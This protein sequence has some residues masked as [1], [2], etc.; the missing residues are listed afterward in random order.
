MHKSVYEF[1][2]LSDL[3]TDYRKLKNIPLDNWDRRWIS[4]HNGCASACAMR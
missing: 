4:A 3:T 1:E 2:F